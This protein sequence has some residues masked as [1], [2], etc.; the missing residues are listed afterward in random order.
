MQELQSVE[1]NGRAGDITLRKEVL[2]EDGWGRNWA[3]PGK[4]GKS[5][6]DEQAGVLSY[7]WSVEMNIRGVAYIFTV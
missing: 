2:R 5:I 7:L 6:I 3:L 4:F 1:R